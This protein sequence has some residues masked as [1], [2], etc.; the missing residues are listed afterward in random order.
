MEVTGAVENEGRE[1]WA[2]LG[3]E[4][5]Q[6]ARW[7][8]K[9]QLR[10]PFRRAD[11]AEGDGVRIPRIVEIQVHGFCQSLVASARFLR[12]TSGQRRSGVRHPESTNNIEKFIRKY[13]NAPE[14]EERDLICKVQDAFRVFARKASAVLGRHGRSSRNHMVDL[15]RMSDHELQREFK[16]IGK[17]ADETKARVPEV[18]DEIASR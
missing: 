4:L 17:K 13:A 8:R 11:C 6:Q 16:R 10:S 2:L 7:R 1:H 15:G 9:P 14:T 5:L 12:P 3:E 18:E